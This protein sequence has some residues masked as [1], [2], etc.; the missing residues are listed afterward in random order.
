MF[1][2]ARKSLLP[3]CVFRREKS[4]TCEKFFGFFLILQRH[5]GQGDAGLATSGCVYKCVNS[6][7]GIERPK[8]EMISGIFFVIIKGS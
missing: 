7:E 8:P 5:L 2:C 1:F 4:I 3:K 6:K